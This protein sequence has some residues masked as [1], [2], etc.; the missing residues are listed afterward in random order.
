VAATF[1]SDAVLQTITGI[2]VDPSTGELSNAGSWG[3]VWYSASHGANLTVTVGVNDMA[4]SSQQSASAP[5]GVAIIP[6]N[7]ADS[8]AVL[9][10]TNGHRDPSATLVNAIVFNLASYP[11]A[12]HQAVWA[13]NFNGTGATNQLVSA[14]GVY[15]GPE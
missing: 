1:A 3:F 4:S 9:T 5:S 14:A 7:W 2:G 11:Q 12:P 6:S 13:M 8:S 15:I 10:A